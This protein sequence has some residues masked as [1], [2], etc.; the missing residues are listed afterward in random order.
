[1][2]LIMI[3]RIRNWTSCWED[4]T[5][6]VFTISSPVTYQRLAFIPNQAQA[7]S[8]TFWFH[9]LLQRC[10]HYRYPKCHCPGSA[11]SPNKCTRIGY[12]RVR[13]A[14]ECRSGQ[15]E[16]PRERRIQGKKYELEGQRRGFE[17]CH[18]RFQGNLDTPRQE[19]TSGHSFGIYIRDRFG[20]QWWLWRQKKEENLEK[21]CI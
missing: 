9:G 2:L 16:Q 7:Y 3:E 5:W 18:W 12:N 11:G 15:I 10:S 19:M 20:N 17:E 21:K 1:M 14:D 13:R 8:P 6:I 4:I